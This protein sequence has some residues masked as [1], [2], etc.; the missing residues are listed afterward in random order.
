MI[1]NLKIEGSANANQVQSVD[2]HQ[3]KVPYPVVD[4]ISASSRRPKPFGSR[5]HIANHDEEAFIDQELIDGRRKRKAASTDIDAS[6]KPPAC[7]VQ[8]PSTS[9]AHLH[10]ISST[11]SFASLG[12][13]Q[14]GVEKKTL[15]GGVA[16]NS[17][18]PACLSLN[19]LTAAIRSSLDKTNMATSFV[20][21][22]TNNNN[23]ISDSK[24]GIF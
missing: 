9:N 20:N 7:S 1:L 3:F 5:E 19:E 17:K 22:N 2:S 15:C 14:V 6:T 13:S 4:E 8:K 16:P 18:P 24:E 21:N 11:S 23:K 12:S 10:K